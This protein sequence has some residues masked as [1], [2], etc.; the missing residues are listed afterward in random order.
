MNRKSNIASRMLAFTMAMIVPVTLFGED[1]STLPLP[2][3]GN[4][5]LT[6]TEYDRLM[7]L[8]SKAAKKREQP[9]VAYTI[10]HADLKLRVTEDAVLGTVMEQGEV[11]SKGA[12]KVPLANG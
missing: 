4:V 9:P 11:F 1:K 6:L 2:A 7:D 10:K 8:A 12:A 3:S 5:T